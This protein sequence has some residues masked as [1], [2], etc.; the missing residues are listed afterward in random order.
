[1]KLNNILTFL[2]LIVLM[3]GCGSGGGSNA[4]PTNSGGT[5]SSGSPSNTVTSSNVLA[6]TVNDPSYPNKP[7]VSVTVCTPG[8]ANCQTIDNILLDTGSYGLRIFKQTLQNVSLQQLS[9]RKS[10]V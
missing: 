9:D 1:M 2:L 3:A 7:T 5:G 10:V 8:T 4:P 6:I